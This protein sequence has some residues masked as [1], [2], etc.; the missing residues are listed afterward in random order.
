[1]PYCNFVCSKKSQKMKKHFF[2]ILPVI[3]SIFLSLNFFW[4][5]PLVP[6]FDA[7]FYL[8]EIKTFSIHFPNPLTYPYLDRY[9]T[10]VFP[11][12]LSIVFGLDPVASYRIAISV[13]YAAISFALFAIFKNITKKDSQAMVLVSAIVISPFLI[14]YSLLFANFTAFLILFSFFAIETGKDFKYKNIVLGIIFGLIF[15]IHNFSTVSFGL[16]FAT[17]FLLKFIFT[18]D[19]KVIKQ[20]AVIFIIAAVVGFVGL[21]RYLN[22]DLTFGHGVR[23]G[24]PTQPLAIGSE[25]KIILDAVMVYTGKFWLYYF[26][27]FTIISFIFFRK[28]LLTN[29]KY[30]LIPAAI[31]LPSLILSF[32]PLYHLN[33]LPDRFATL[34]CLSTYFFY[35]A[36]ISLPAFK[37]FIVPL[38]VMPLLLNYLSS[39]S[40]ILN[41]GYRD[42]TDQEIKVYQ[43]VKPLIAADG[44]ILVPSDHYYWSKYFLYDH[45]IY[46][47]EHFVSCGDITKP[48]YLGDINFTFAK[49]LAETDLQ[50][51]DAL[52]TH[53][54]SITPA[55]EIYILTDEGLS[56]GDGKIL[57]KIKSVK[58]IFNEGN[59]HLYEI[60]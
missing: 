3:L 9:L 25:K 33:Y 58:Q 30:F 16:I 6:G 59:W 51:A 44:I 45:M 52:L 34:V 18:K 37:K 10:M 7:P 57:Q 50:K 36:A 38:A 29:K 5:K 13:I 35:V 54:E 20:T 60:N 14:N 23:L 42:F 11:A 43:E 21:A 15:Y 27:G 26:T 55:K 8:T 1:M 32:Q 2:W 40:L 53:L 4:S 48:G 49:L 24:V 47:G 19:V 28:K 31:F 46:E 56:C 41:K 39:D 22:I 17:Y 12:I